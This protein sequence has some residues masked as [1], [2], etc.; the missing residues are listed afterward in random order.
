MKEWCNFRA[1]GKTFKARITGTDEY[2]RLMLEDPK[3][4]ITVWPFKGVQM[5]WDNQSYL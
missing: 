3:G 5:L 1:E 2:G 4:K